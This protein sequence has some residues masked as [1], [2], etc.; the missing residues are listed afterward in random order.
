MSQNTENK[1]YMCEEESKL[2][3]RLRVR[4]RKNNY[5]Y[6]H[7]KISKEKYLKNIDNLL[8][9]VDTLQMRFNDGPNCVKCVHW[10][11]CTCGEE[12][13][14]KGTSIGYSVGECKNY[15]ER[16]K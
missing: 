13:H 8:F 4:R 1:D 14:R 7:G 15:E 10:K 5:L 16:K 6:R 3:E 9:D 2:F 11:T 12:G